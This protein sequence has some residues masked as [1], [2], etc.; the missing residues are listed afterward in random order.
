MQLV[1]EPLARPFWLFEGLAA[2]DLARTFVRYPEHDATTTMIG[3]GAGALDE[4]VKL[5]GILRL[6]GVQQ[7]GYGHLPSVDGLSSFG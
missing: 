5:E 7:L 1:D 2:H 6:F 3:H 4:R